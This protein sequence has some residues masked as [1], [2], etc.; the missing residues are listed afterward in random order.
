[1]FEGCKAV[2]FHRKIS[3]ALAAFA[4]SIV[5]MG[6]PAEANDTGIANAGKAVAIAL[7]VA[8]AAISIFK[9]DWDGGVQLLLVTGAT[10]GTALVLKHFVHEER[11]DHSD[12]QSFPSDQAALA[13]APAAYLWDRYGW[14]YGVPAYA[15]AAFVGYARVESKQHHWWDVA[16]SAGIAWTYSK[17]IT[18]EYHPPRG[19]DSGVYATPD[20]A[21]ISLDYRF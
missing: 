16:A 4:A 15:A 9:D 10:A 11:P 12:N 14:Q 20:G 18:T 8:A 3:A 1:M 13:F 17:I 7:P 5:L 2:N 19:F 6:A 21:Y